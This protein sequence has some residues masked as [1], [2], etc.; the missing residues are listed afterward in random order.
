[1]QQ[2]INSLDKNKTFELVPLPFNWKAIEVKWVYKVK[3][4]SDN[5]INKYK[6]QL[7]T[8]GFTK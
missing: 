6:A 2:E 3:L 7:C 4:N 5:T 1:M 8:K